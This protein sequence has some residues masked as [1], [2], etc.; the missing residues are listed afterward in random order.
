LV[1][2]Q[3]RHSSS[4]LQLA[5]VESEE[6]EL[7]PA[8]ARLQKRS[9]LEVGNFKVQILLLDLY[10]KN[11]RTD[12]A[13]MLVNKMTREFPLEP[14]FA[15]KKAEILIVNR[16]IDNAKIHLNKIANLWL[17][18]PQKLFSLSS[19]Q[20]SVND[21][22]GANDSLLKALSYLPQHLMLNLDYARLNLQ[23]DEIE[24]TEKWQMRCC[25]NIKR[26]QTFPY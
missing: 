3:P 6:N 1:E 8:I 4:Q 19:M 15:I 12:T 16:E 25:D 18:N 17:G 24:I 2:D 23:L 20:Q 10:L 22:A 21:Y 9:I 26:A 14:K 5:L 7:A 11:E 13:L